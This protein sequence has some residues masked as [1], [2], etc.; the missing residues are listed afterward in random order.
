RER[1]DAEVAV[2]FRSL[3]ASLAR[4]RHTRTVGG[5]SVS[6]QTADAVTPD[7]PAGPEEGMT[8]TAAPRR[9]IASRNSARGIIVLATCGIGNLCG[10]GLARALPRRPPLFRPDDRPARRCDLFAPAAK[11]LLLARGRP[12]YKGA[13][14]R[15]PRGRPFLSD[16]RWNPWICATLRS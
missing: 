9:L 12:L 6:E 14:G 7:W 4:L 16:I 11:G 8:C 10:P 13:S 5:S 15:P 3:L 1:V 2:A